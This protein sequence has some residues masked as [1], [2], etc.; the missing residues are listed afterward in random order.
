MMYYV[1]RA[2]GFKYLY[3]APEDFKKVSAMNSVHAELIEDEGESRYKIIDIIG[4]WAGADQGGPVRTTYT[5][6]YCPALY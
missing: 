2:Q 6:L 1:L 3:L 4:E 5:A